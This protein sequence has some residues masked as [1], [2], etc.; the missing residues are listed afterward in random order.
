MWIIKEEYYVKDKE[1]RRGEGSSM[2]YKFTVENDNIIKYEIPKDGG[3]YGTSVKEIFPNYIA[4]KILSYKNGKDRAKFN[5]KVK[6][7]Y[8][9]LEI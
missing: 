3:A 4:K 2:P 5:E 8:S 7:H 6:S 1:L 9:Y